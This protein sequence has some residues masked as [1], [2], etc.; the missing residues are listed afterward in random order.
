MRPDGPLQAFLVLDRAGLG[1][2]VVRKRWAYGKQATSKGAEPRNPAP[3][4]PQNTEECTLNAPRMLQYLGSPPAN[5]VVG[6]NS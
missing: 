2:A 5:I 4:L 3:R 1:V 6:T